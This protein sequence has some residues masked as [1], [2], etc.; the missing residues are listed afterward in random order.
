MGS[1]YALIINDVVIIS[2]L[3]VNMELF[4]DTI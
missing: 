4:S 1:G 3:V 2:Q